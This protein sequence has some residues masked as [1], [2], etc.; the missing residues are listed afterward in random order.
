MEGLLVDL[1]SISPA[2]AFV[3]AAVAVSRK[4]SPGSP[5]APSARFPLEVRGDWQSVLA[6]AEVEVVVDGLKWSEGPLCMGDSLYFTDTIDAIIYRLSDC[7]LTV[8]LRTLVVLTQPPRLISQSP[9]R[10]EWPPT[11]RTRL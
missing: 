4:I 6:S 5:I 3:M 8:G 11:Y 9:V 2:S 7:E 1:E 10:M